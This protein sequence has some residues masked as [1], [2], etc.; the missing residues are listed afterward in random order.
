MQHELARDDLYSRFIAWLKI[1]LPLAA[2]G[3]LST[4]FLLSRSFDQQVAIPFAQRD[5]AERAE[6]EQVTA[7]YFS[8]AT[9]SG[10]LVT[11]TAT[12]AVP[13]STQPGRATMNGIWARINTNHSEITLIAQSG[14]VDEPKDTSVLTGDVIIESSSGYRMHTQELTSALRE[15]NAHS[16]GPVWGTGS[17]GDLNAGRMIITSDDQTGAVQLL[18][19]QGVKLVYR[20]EN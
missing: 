11:L 2:L 12:N 3:L 19:T 1:L 15:V 5:L 4:L 16:A 20:P 17:G 9:S 18:F 7:P 14:L 8:G 13:D 6:R 10:A